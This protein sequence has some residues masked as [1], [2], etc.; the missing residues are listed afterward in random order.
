MTDCDGFPHLSGHSRARIRV[1][2]KTC[3]YASHLSLDRAPTGAR[4]QRAVEQRVEQTAASGAATD[5]RSTSE[6]LAGG[7]AMPA[8]SLPTVTCEPAPASSATQTR[9]NLMWKKGRNS[10]PLEG[11]ASATGPVNKRIWGFKNPSFV[12]R[13]GSQ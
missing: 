2:R 8:Q 4:S 3:H 12:S 10:I 1:I 5:R 7:G 13:L 6:P 9:R 11:H